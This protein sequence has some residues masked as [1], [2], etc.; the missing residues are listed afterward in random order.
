SYLHAV[1]ESDGGFGDV[2]ATSWVLQ[3]ATALGQSAFDWSA[4]TYEMPDYYIATQQEL[5]GGIGPMS[6][7]MQ[8]RI[9]ATAYAVPAIER[10]TWDLL[11]TSFPKPTSTPL[12]LGASTSTTATTTIAT[13]SV[14]VAPEAVIPAKVQPIS[15]SVPARTQQQPAA[16]AADVPASTSTPHAARI[17]ASAEEGAPFSWIRAAMAILLP[18][19]F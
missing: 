1:Q 4:G 5:D 3:A 15:V 12:V 6:D 2:S 8:T 17:V 13:T 14:A 9:W 11:L 10:K 19:F 18:W 7:D 16:Y